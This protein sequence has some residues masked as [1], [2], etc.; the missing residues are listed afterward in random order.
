VYGLERKNQILA[1]DLTIPYVR[2]VMGPVSYTPL[3]FDRSA[4]SRGYQLAQVV[5]YEA[6]I[7]IFAERHDHLR[8]FEA[9]K[10]LE[11]VPSTWDETRFL[12][13]YPASHAIY[14]RRKG[15]VWYVGGISGEA[16][17]V[18]V[19]L[20]FLPAGTPHQATIYRDADDRSKIV[21]ETRTV[22]S[23]DV[24]TLALQK[25]GGFVVQLGP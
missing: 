17:T 18:K 24:L 7:Q 23:K 10:F 13:G 5:I 25:A 22:T 8:A 11:T 16:R 6:G 1:H 19:P 9:V 12:D 15:T 3:R 4:G 14:A 21:Q 20:A 2:N